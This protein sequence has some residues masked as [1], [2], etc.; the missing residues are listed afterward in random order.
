MNNEEVKNGIES[1]VKQRWNNY[2]AVIQV[3]QSY[4]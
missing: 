2:F 3:E 4:V 1:L